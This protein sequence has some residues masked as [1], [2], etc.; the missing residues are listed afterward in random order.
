MRTKTF[1]EWF[2]DYGYLYYE[3][4]L[5][6]LDKCPNEQVRIEIVGNESSEDI[7]RDLTEIYW[8]N[9]DYREEN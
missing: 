6:W 7:A 9:I 5:D 2:N 4:V 1:E 3:E 8:E